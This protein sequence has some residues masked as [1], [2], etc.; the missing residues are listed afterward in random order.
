MSAVLI[1]LPDALTNLVAAALCGALLGLNRQFHRKPAGLRTHAMVALGAALAVLTISR[2]AGADSG[3]VSRIMQ[4]TV[5]GIGFIGAGVIIH[6]T[7]KDRVEGLT[8]AASIWLAAM[9]GLACGA[10]QWQ[11]AGGALVLALVILM[12][13]GRLEK[14]LTRKLVSTEERGGAANDPGHTP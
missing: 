12:F 9:L 10:G 6:H 4:G 11:L 13:G 7:E 1:P 2:V 3:D 8:T 5:T 14:T